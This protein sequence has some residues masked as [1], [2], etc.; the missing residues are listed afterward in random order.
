MNEGVDAAALVQI[1]LQ[2]PIEIR[3]ILLFL[4][5]LAVG[6]QVNRGVY[7][8]AWRPRP[9][10]PWSPPHPQA[11]ARRWSDRLPI[12]G[13][14]G[15]RRE[16]KLHGRGYWVRPALLE[17]GLGAFFAWLYWWE[18]NGGLYPPGVTP[19]FPQAP[20]HTQYFSHLLLVSLMAVATFI[21]FDEK[22]IPDAITVP[23]LLLGLLL[24][25]LAPSSH[26][27]VVTFSP[28]AAAPEFGNLRLTSPNA[29]PP[30]LNAEPRWLVVAMALYLGWCLAVT[31][32]TW[33]ARRGVVKAYAYWATSIIRYGAIW[34]LVLLAAIGTP[35]I[36]G[37]WLASGARWEAMFSSLVGMAFG[38]GLVWAVRI[39]A[40]AAL[41]KE[42][43]GFGDVTLMAMIGAY[44][45]WQPSLYI[46]FLAPFLGILIAIGQWIVT[47]RPDIAYG[48]YLCAATVA[49][50]VY[51]GEIWTP[52]LALIFALGWFVPVALV[53]CLALMGVL[54]TGLQLLKALIFR[55]DPR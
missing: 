29:W 33:T 47:R 8:L 3:L 25:L 22:T 39:I 32:A 34:R 1:W 23:G 31:P 51:W 26:L 6:G 17:L 42:A 21:D 45:G 24:A 15:L 49:L 16:G 7:R 10:G 30:E 54:L 18:I 48:P 19:P 9:I 37:A 27:P 55:D 13:W 2:I 38:G 5:G 44:V 40:G 35:L 43:M 50:F 53:V 20:L 41:G 46:F 11:P 12:V 14:W 4:A 36:L 52:W 28:L